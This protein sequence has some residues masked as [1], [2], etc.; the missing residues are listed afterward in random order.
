[1]ARP[2][3]KGASLLAPALEA[4]G[5]SRRAALLEVMSQVRLLR[6][7][8][9]DELAE[10]AATKKAPSTTVLARWCTTWHLEPFETISVF[11]LPV[12]DYWRSNDDARRDRSWT[13]DVLAWTGRLEAD[14]EHSYKRQ[15][16]DPALPIEAYPQIECWEQFQQRAQHHW[17]TKVDRLL[18]WGKFGLDIRKARTQPTRRYTWLVQYQLLGMSIGDIAREHQVTQTTVSQGVTLA[19]EAAAIQLRPRSAPGRPARRKT[20]Q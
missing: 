12:V 2:R 19:A 13:R 6:P 10:L 16:A 17:K 11:L 9:L 15:H 8:A 1:M 14:S 4:E 7:S 20:P 3:K 5:N 18:A